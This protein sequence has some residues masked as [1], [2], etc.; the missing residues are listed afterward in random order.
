ME[1]NRKVRGYV[2]GK[3]MSL[4]RTAKPS[5]TVQY[6]TSSIRYL[7]QQDNC[8]FAQPKQKVS[9]IVQDNN[10]D[11]IT[12]YDSIYAVPGDEKIDMKA[13]S[14]ISSAQERFKA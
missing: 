6:T 7:V 9:F 12:S 13:A 1:A 4:Y 3:L 14:Y 10:R 8:V 5:S 2:K 11:L